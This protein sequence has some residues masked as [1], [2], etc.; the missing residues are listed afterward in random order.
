MTRRVGI[1]ARVST[2]NKRRKI[3]FASFAHGLRTLGILS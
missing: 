3:S 2:G 1:Y